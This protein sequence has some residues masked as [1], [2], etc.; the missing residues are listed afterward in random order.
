MVFP[1]YKKLD[2]SKI[3]KEILS[4]WEEHSIFNKSVSNADS[5]PPYIFYE[6]PPS[7]NG[8]PGIHHVLARTIKDIFLRYKTMKGY[9]VKR[10]AGWDTHGLPVE[11]GVENALGIS[12]EDIGNKV[13]IEEYNLACKKAVMK[14]TDIWNDLTKKMGYWVDMEDPYITYTAKYMESVWWLLNQVYKK[15]LMY[16]GYTV[17]PYSP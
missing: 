7:A 12:K 17:Q 3:D 15:D 9:Q 4:Y 13:S 10:K 8:L 1:E 11:L 6:G 14:Y 16:K 5:N 2:L